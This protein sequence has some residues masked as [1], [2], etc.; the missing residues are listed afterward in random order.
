M[1]DVVRLGRGVFWVLVVVLVMLLVATLD[2]LPAVVASRFDV[3][4]A[5]N[6]WSS[7]PVY[8]TLILVIGAVLPLGIVSLVQTLTRRGTD[9]LNLPSAD[10]WRRP[11]HA[12]E[13]VRRVREYIWWLAC[14]MAGTAVALHGLIVDANS[15]QPPQLATPAILTLIVVVVAAIGLW[16]VGWW[17]LLRPPRRSFHP[18]AKH[19]RG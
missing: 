3:H 15:S 14:I 8:A 11:E 9:R 19:S 16:T 2:R 1:N 13:A 6:G 12:A 4:G 5:P 10:Y 18:P 17:F 7:R